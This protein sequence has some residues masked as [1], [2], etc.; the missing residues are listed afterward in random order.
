MNNWAIIGLYV[1]VGEPPG[2]K[3]VIS[4]SKEKMYLDADGTRPLLLGML[5]KE[6]DKLSKE[7]V[8]PAPCCMMLLC[9]LMPGLPHQNDN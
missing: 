1:T 6:M 3:K 8:E 2:A 9:P 7:F 5:A 4:D